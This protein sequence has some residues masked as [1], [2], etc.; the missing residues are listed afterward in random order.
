[1]VPVGHAGT[2]LDYL[3][4]YD[5]AATDMAAV[6]GASNQLTGQDVAICQAV[7]RNLDAGIYDTGVLSPRHEDGVAW[8]QSQVAGVHP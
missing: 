5:P 6:L 7:Q 1:M 2:R 4:F 3:Y 8:F